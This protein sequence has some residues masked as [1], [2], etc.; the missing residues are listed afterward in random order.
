MKY[1]Y[2]HSVGG[3]KSVIDNNSSTG[4]PASV[5]IMGVSQGGVHDGDTAEAQI[6]RIDCMLDERVS[7]RR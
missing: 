5:F 1:K 7:S 2:D 6:S 4:R 3:R